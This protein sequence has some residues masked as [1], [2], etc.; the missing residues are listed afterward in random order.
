MSKIDGNK[1]SLKTPIIVHRILIRKALKKILK[2]CKATYIFKYIMKIRRIEWTLIYWRLRYGNPP[3]FIHI[4]K[5]GGTYLAQLEKD[6]ESVVKPMINLG[7]TCVINK[8]ISTPEDFP[9]SFKDK[10]K[11]DQNWL[12]NY[13]VFSIVRNIFDWLVSYWGHAGGHNPKYDSRSH[14]DYS[15]AQK[16]FEYLLKTIANR[17]NEW[18]SRK[19]IHFAIFSCHGNL[20]V[21]WI[22]RTETLDED[23]KAMAKYKHLNYSK[24]EK[25]RVGVRD[26][27]YR[28]YYNDKLIE[29][30]YNT[31]GR[32]LKLFGYTFEGL[33][34][35]KAVLKRKI[36]FS[37]K[38]NINY[39][40]KDDRLII[41][42]KEIKR[43]TDV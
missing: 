38:G 22:N 15:I 31:W 4:P 7:H 20:I 13:F 40:L 42:N 28:S 11:Y 2:I 35:Q 23:L 34:I 25:Q 12:K 8:S 33:N 9:H 3:V 24:K 1:K 30:V 17:E 43:N 10:K 14:Y 41:N 27:D 37:E 6:K 39:F 19:F 36:D 18:P 26:R 5:T 16:G 21:D 32:E 29:L